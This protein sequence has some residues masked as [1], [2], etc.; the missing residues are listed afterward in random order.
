MT[1]LERALEWLMTEW[2]FATSQLMWADFWA[3]R[4]LGL[5]MAM[6]G[7]LVAG[8][9]VTTFVMVDWTKKWL[10]GAKRASR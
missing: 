2:G 3:W 4:A 10:F 8:A 5:L 9:F 1:R 6:V 7:I